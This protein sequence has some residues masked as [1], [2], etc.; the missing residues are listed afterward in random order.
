MAEADVALQTLI[1]DAA[2][3]FPASDPNEKNEVTLPL[4]TKISG[5]TGGASGLD[6]FPNA[7]SKLAD[8]EGLG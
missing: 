8:L 2:S 6:Q 3:H 5:R 1:P 7:L 4:Q